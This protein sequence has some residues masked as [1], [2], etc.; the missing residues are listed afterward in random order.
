[1]SPMLVGWFG[2]VIL[3][4]LLFLGVPIAF[5]MIICGFA[6]IAIISSLFV[7]LQV[8]EY[9][10]FATVGVY[11][12]TV[13]P[14]FILMGHFALYSGVSS[15][16]FDVA[17]KWFGR[18]PGGLAVATVVGCAGFAATTGSS[19]ACAAT[20]G[21][22]ALPEMRKYKYSDQFATGVVAA[23]GTLGVL[24][25]PST[26][27]VI[28]AWLTQLSVAE[29]LVAGILPGIFSALV[30]ILV[31]LVRAKL[32]PSIAPPATA[33]RWKDAIR[34]VWRVWGILTIIGVIIGVIYSGLCTVTEAAAAGTFATLLLGVFNGT[35]TW[36]GF[37]QSV[38]ETA[39]TTSM[40]FF[41]VVGTSLFTL[42][43]TLSG[44]P[45]WLA[46]SASAL[47]L[48]HL[49]VLC[50]ILLIYIPLGMFLDPTSI[51]LLTVPI[52]Y[53][54][55][56][57]FGYDGIWF[58]VIVTVFIEIAL[59]TPPV[60]FNVFVIAGIA[61]D[62]PLYEIFRGVFWFIIAEL[63][64]VAVL[65]AFPQMSLYLPNLMRAGR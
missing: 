8:L 61:K 20:M 51:L 23:G 40:L 58:G 29:Q 12:L 18:L 39:R 49:L 3:M 14:L 16:L 43:M 4:L 48:P 26:I 24:I 64:I 33:V 1:M 37:K 30:L 47:P 28:Y 9:H 22:V 11:L 21:R 25:P 5:A 38:L 31:V 13:V 15:D 59:I 54:V 62:V 27:A 53:P 32:N 63:A 41:I 34:S 56:V 57:A 44:I 60:G 55:V 6:G 10:A 52:V 46:N 36:A 17:Y 45:I 2:I 50:L 65:I 19:V 7:S 35:M 42:F